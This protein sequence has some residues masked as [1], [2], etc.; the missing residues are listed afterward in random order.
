MK[1]KRIYRNLDEMSLQKNYLQIIKYTL[2]YFDN[3]KSLA[4]LLK[5][6]G[7]KDAYIGSIYIN[8]FE[9]FIMNKQSFFILRKELTAK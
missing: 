1:T 4:S 6:R 5:I 3:S 8:L 2:N 9:N 7:E